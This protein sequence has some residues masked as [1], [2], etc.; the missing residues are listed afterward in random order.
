M[1]RI[2]LKI[3]SITKFR[4]CNSVDF[5]FHNDINV[6]TGLNGAGKTSVLD[7]IYYITN[8]RS[9]FSNLDKF[10]YKDDGDYFRISGKLVFEENQFDIEVTS[11]FKKGKKIFLDEKQMKSI[12][13]FYGK[14][15]SFMIAPKDIQILV[16]SS[17][18]RRKLM[19]KTLS[20]VDRSYLR[21]LLDYNKALKQRNAALKTFQKTGRSDI[22][23]LNA[24]NE[25]MSIPAQ[26]I[27]DQRQIFVEKISPI[28]NR[29][30]SELSDDRE[31]LTISYKSRLFDH[32]FIELQDSSLQKDLILAKTSEGIHRDDAILRIN[33]FEMKKYASQG[34]L[35]SAIISLKLAQIEWVK[36]M[37][38]K[39]P[40]LLLD[41]IFDKLDNERV[42]NLIDICVNRLDAQV[43]I[44]DTDAGRVDEILKKLNKDYNHYYIKDG[45]L[46]A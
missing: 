6:L 19:D 35:K 16:E 29:Y 25:K 21:H 41:D 3:L 11:S 4:N 10:L 43:F 45:N 24:I 15:P 38:G 27:F 30:Y 44:S 20:Q 32:T 12:S 34:Q 5:L 36:S 9:Y 39:I 1:N 13:S 7:T 18:E 17:I 40:I 14:F 2:T 33:D 28:F 42:K 46:E 37:T 23:L 22:I 8:G 31:K 26:Y